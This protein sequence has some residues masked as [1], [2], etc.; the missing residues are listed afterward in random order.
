[1][2]P[3]S[4]DSGRQRAVPLVLAV[5]AIVLAWVLGRA[6]TLAHV[7]P[8]WWLDTPAVA[9]FYGLLWKGYDRWWWRLGRAG[10]TLSGIPDFGGTWTGT[11]L[12][13]YRPDEP[14]AV[15]VCILQTAS[16]IHVELSTARSRSHSQLAMI[17]SS[18]GPGHGLRYVYG[19]HPE[20]LPVP[21]V[22]KHDGSAYLRLSADGRTLEGGY[23]TDPDRGN[24]GTMTLTRAEEPA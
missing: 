5:V 4:T 7:A 2:H 1:M 17:C 18:P 20:G 10:R 12:T 13:S 16:R 14:H 6:F 15:R 22:S 21:G 3:Y 11:L 23:S 8:P 24:R 19:N 9:G